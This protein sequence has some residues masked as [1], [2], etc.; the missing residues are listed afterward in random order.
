MRYLGVPL[1]I[2]QNSITLWKPLINKFK[3]SLS[4]W[5]GSYLNMAGKLVLLKATLD[6]L[7]IYWFNLFIMPKGIKQHIDIMRR[8]FL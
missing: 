6:S 7:P 5:K 3:N 8:N 1:G 4:N 2:Q